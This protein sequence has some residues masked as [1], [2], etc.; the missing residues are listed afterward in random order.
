MTL[1]ANLTIPEVITGEVAGHFNRV[2][3]VGILKKIRN[4][5]EPGTSGPTDAA[6]FKQDAEEFLKG[7]KPVLTF[8]KNLT[9]DTDYSFLFYFHTAQNVTQA[10]ASKVPS[11]DLIGNDSVVSISVNQSVT[12]TST[13]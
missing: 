1:E 2:A 4:F 11:G 10:E 6:I 8:V 3:R 12:S 9:E 5:N 7:K 13:A